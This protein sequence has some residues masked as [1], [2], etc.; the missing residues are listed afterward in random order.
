VDCP[1]IAEFHALI[2][3]MAF[4]HGYSLS[5]WQ[6][7]LQV[8]LEK[9]PGAICIADLHALGLLEADFNAAMK[10]LVGHCMAHQDLQNNLNPLECYGSIPSH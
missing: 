1:R 9:K 10:I 7:S 8:L 6:P 4:K 3:E 2:T 5:H